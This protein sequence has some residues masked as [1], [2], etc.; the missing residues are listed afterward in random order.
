M[1]QALAPIISNREVMPG[2][3]LLWLEAPQIATIAHAGHFIMSSCGD[4]TLLRRPLSIHQVDRSKIA[5]LFSV[6]GKGTRWLSQRQAGDSLDL[7][8]PMGNGF[9]LENSPQ[10]LLLLAGGLGIAPLRFLADSAL[11]NGY[12]VT[13]LAGAGTVSQL[14][15][16][17]L[18]P[19][20]IHCIFATE[21]GS[22]GEKGKITDLLPHYLDRA[23]QIFACGPLA[24]YRTM[25]QMPE[26]QNKSV[27]VSLEM[28]M[29]CGLGA[30]YGCTIR[31]KHGLKQ[32]CKD[33]PVFNLNDIVWDELL[34]L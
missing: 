10:R 15:P 5:F 30:C 14:Y 4:A 2:V 1:K 13:L 17:E 28:R 16:Q 23:D 20:E 8:G 19:R 3:Y 32:V 24:M 25:S 34:R 18:L 21:D 11:R 33:G 12:D 27:Q 6:V 26:L 22:Y 29:A 9:T 7:L 31:T